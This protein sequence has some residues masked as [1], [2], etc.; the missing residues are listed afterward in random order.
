MS[1]AVQDRRGISLE[2]YL[3]LGM[4]MSHAMTANRPIDGGSAC[5]WY[6]LLVTAQATM[7]SEYSKSTGISKRWFTVVIVVSVNVYI[8]KNFQYPNAM[9]TDDTRI[10]TIAPGHVFLFADPSVLNE[11]GYPNMSTLF[12]LSS[13]SLRI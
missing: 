6:L 13:C 1:S 5:L 11:M 2:L 9:T 12:T 4:S 3:S 7:K 10:V 8:A